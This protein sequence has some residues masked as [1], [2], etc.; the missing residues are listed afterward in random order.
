MT[1]EQF[2]EK[3]KEKFPDE[4]YKIIYYGANSFEN[5]IIEC[6]SCHKKIT[7]NTGELFRKRKKH[8][9]SHCCTLREDTVKNREFI[10]NSIKDEAYNIEFF[11]KKQS[12]NGN[13]GAAVRFTCK[14]CD[15]I[16]EIFV[17]NVLRSEGKCTCQRCSGQKIYKDDIIFFQE[18]EERFPQKFT[19][20]T[21]YKNVKE[22]IKVRCNNCNFIRNVKPD[23]LLKYGYCPKCGKSKSSG[24]QKISSWLENNNIKYETQKYFKDWNIGIHYFDFY[25][26]DYNLVIEYNG[27]Q[28]YIFNPYFHHTEEN[29]NYRLKKDAQK[30]E[31]A[32]LSGLNYL[33]IKY[34]NYSSLEDILTKVISSTTILEGSRGKSLEIEAFRKE[35]DIVWT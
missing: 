27:I 30:K 16:N 28:H 33:S 31:A 20:L 10:Y 13:K 32:L 8:L 17:G 2:D 21:P 6:L 26:P 15:F 29:F 24:E 1:K 3:M 5:S 34:T 22:D 11:M 25:L 4:S 12:K 23:T 18:L 14:K 7:I 35:E 19:L 9:C